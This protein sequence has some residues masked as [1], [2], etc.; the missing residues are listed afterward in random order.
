[1]E[2]AFAHAGAAFRERR[3]VGYGPAF[4]DFRRKVEVARGGTID[5]VRKLDKKPRL[6]SV[7]SRKRGVRHSGLEARQ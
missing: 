6:P 2:V 7:F 3:D 4:L 1:M 5:F